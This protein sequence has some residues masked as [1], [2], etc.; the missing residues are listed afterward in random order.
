[1]D[2]LLEDITKDI[3]EIHDNKIEESEM[4]Q[5]LLPEL[6]NI[7]RQNLDENISIEELNID[8]EDESDQDA[9]QQSNQIEPGLKRIEKHFQRIEQNE[10]KRQDRHNPRPARENTQAKFNGMVNLD[11]Y[12]LSAIEDEPKSYHEALNSNESYQWKKAMDEEINSLKQN[13]TWVLVDPP[14]NCKVIGCKWVLKKKLNK[15]GLV[16]R[17]KA[18]LVA[19]GCSQTKGIDYNETFAPVVKYKSLRIILALVTI[20]NYEL[21]QMDLQTAFLNAAIEEDVYMEQPE[22]YQKGGVK[23]VCK[24]L[25]LYM[26]QN[27]HHITGMK[28]LMH[29]RYHWVLSGAIVIHV[30]I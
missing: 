6:Q 21:N 3:N 14:Q 17:Y 4:K 29:S 27:R 23:K 10:V 16:A 19:K 13:N 25:K 5:S 15:E 22:G 28:I 18:R 7:Q 1:M 30:Y 11:D 2:S 26:E 8:E 24:L 20:L 12:I 9:K